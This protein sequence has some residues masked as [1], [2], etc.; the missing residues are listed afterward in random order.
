[1]LKDAI[2]CTRT[3]SS[4]SRF[5]VQ[6]AYPLAV[7]Q[8]STAVEHANSSY[9]CD[10]DISCAARRYPP[11][12]G[13]PHTPSSCAAASSPCC[14]IPA[15][16]TRSRTTYKPAILSCP[17]RHVSILPQRRLM[18]DAIGMPAS[19]SSNTPAGSASWACGCRGEAW[20]TRSARL[21]LR[22]TNRP[23]RTPTHIMGTTTGTRSV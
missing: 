18:V 2:S 20:R 8:C 3:S 11:S 13:I 12:V 21:P 6:G 15:P 10:W 19:S 7:Q 4:A 16:K 1:M 9:L 14:L 17:C 5:A 23:A 22:P